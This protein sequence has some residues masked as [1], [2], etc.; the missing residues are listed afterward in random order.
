MT[1]SSDTDTGAV[2]NGIEPSQMMSLKSLNLITGAASQAARTHNLDFV[3][4]RIQAKNSLN[5]EKEAVLPI[6]G[7][8]CKMTP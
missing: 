3:L 7:E 6:Q 2:L 4:G 8:D 1:V 5:E